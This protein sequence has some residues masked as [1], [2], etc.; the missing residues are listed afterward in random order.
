MSQRFFTNQAL[1]LGKFNLEDEQ[2]HHLAN[3]MRKSPGDRIVLFDGSGREFGAVI[4]EIQKKRVALD[5]VDERRIDRELDNEIVVA[6]ALPKGDRQK[7]LVEK[8]VE[9]GVHTLVPLRTQ[10]SVADAKSKVIERLSKQVVE[11]SKQCG[12]NQLMKI[13][14]QQSVAQLIQQPEDFGTRY[15][16]NPYAQTSLSLLFER[17]GQQDANAASIVAIGPEGGFTEEENQ[18]FIDAGWAS[19]RIS[20]TVLRIET[21]ALVAATM[22]RKY[23]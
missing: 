8:L 14:P 11:A 20:P 23:S 2:A 18:A 1:Q 9:V 15:L 19:V 6:C 16:A 4:L 17:S 7:F 21:A 13:S 3:V 12:R 5:V 22:L 10:R